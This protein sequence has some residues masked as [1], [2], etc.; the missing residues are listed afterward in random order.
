[1]PPA[2]LKTPKFKLS[3]AQ[4]LFAAALGIGLLAAWGAYHELRARQENLVQNALG[5]TVQLIVA[6]SNLPAGALLGRSNLAMR[7]IPLRYAPGTGL[8]PSGFDAIEGRKLAYPVRSGEAVTIP[9][10]APIET[11]RLSTLLEPGHRAMTIA[12]GQIDSL[13]GMLK[14]DDRIDVLLTITSG[15]LPAVYTIEQ[16]LPILATG[17][18]LGNKPDA[19]LAENYATVTL[20]VTPAQ[21]HRLVIARSLGTL[22]FLLRTNSDTALLPGPP[23]AIAAVL[24]GQQQAASMQLPAPADNS[25]LPIRIPRGG[26][27]QPPEPAVRTRTERTE[28]TERSVSHRNRSAQRG[29]QVIYGIGGSEAPSAPAAAA[30]TPYAAAMQAAGMAP[31]APAMS[32]LAI[33][34]EQAAAIRAAAARGA[35]APQRYGAASATSAL[36]D[37]VLTMT[38]TRRFPEAPAPSQP[39]L[40]P[41]FGLPASPAPSTAPQ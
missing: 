16:R 2:K 4:I 40:P 27:V 20:D 33:A 25:P 18:Q 15:P 11:R 34:E 24:D 23:A 10:L 9:L 19:P 5:R 8:P 35:P 41:G 39:E 21:A 31:G 29:V 30:V 7:D 38:P 36:P 37:A 3:S 1:M 14:P 6:R 17:Q 13:D 26:Q 12:V 32:A 22:T 28:R